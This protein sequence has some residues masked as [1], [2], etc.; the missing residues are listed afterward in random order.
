[1]LLVG[2]LSFAYFASLVKAEDRLQ[3]EAPKSLRAT[4][5][6]SARMVA[7]VVS[8]GPIMMFGQLAESNGIVSAFRW[9]S[10][11]LLVV[12]FA[13]WLCFKIMVEGRMQKSY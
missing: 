11:I 7:S 1:M 12:S 6:S 3:S 2:A 9:G 8:I 10:A 5:I 13:A 4:S